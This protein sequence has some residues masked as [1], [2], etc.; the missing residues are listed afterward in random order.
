MKRIK[1]KMF[2]TSLDLSQEDMAKVL[3][4][5][6]SQYSQI[7]NGKRDGTLSF[8]KKLQRVFDISDEDMWA[9]AKRKDDEVEENT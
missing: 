7:E 5:S 3:G 9:L 2:R 4:V 1:L 6:R 8:W